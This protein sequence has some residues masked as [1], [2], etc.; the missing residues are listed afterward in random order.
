MTL[1][2]TIFLRRAVRKYDMAPLDA[3]IITDIKNFIDNIAQMDGQTAKLEIVEAKEVNNSMAPHYILAYCEDSDNA[4]A[5]V[6]F[7]LQAVDLYI[8]SLG[9]GSLWLGMAKP[10]SNEPNYCIMLAFGRSDVPFR[11][12]ES[13]FDR[14]PLNKISSEDNSISRAV[15]LAPSAIN[16][17]PWKLGFERGK[18][19]LEYFGRGA[20]KLVVRKK[21]AKIDLGI[22][23]R[24]AVIALEHEGKTIQSLKPVTDRKEFRIEVEYSG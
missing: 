2:E 16:T 7:C 11:T 4:N 18:V 19:I 13:E 1:Y 14:V 6:G 9:L 10:N 3:S 24:H 17:Q 21:L 20:M 8:Q 12:D 5:N 22:A 15:R 23:A